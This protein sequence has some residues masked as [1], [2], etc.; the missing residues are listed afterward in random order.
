VNNCERRYRRWLNLY[1][2]E[3]RDARGEEILATLLEAASD[4]GRLSP[5][6]LLHITWHGAWVRSCLIVRRLCAGRLP[7][8]VYVTTLFM[9]ILAAINLMSAAFSHNGPKNQSSH[10]DNIIVGLVFVGLV[11]VLRTWSG[12]LYPAVIGALVVVVATSFATIDLLIDACAVV[13]LALLVIGRKRYM[14]AIPEVD[15]PQESRRAT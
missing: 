4:H 8:S 7:R 12:R 10:L 15:L 3:Y 5:A 2:K 13:P 1:P 11:L 9:A 14:E 6:D